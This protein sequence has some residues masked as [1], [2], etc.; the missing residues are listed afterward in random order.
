MIIDITDPDSI[1]MAATD[2]LTRFPE[3]NVLGTMAGIMEPED[4]RT[5]DCLRMPPSV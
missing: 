3:L 4:V 2:V 1:T 5:A